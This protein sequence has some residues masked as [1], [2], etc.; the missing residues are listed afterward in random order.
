MSGGSPAA[1][2]LDGLFATIQI[3]GIQADRDRM[4]RG[5][6]GVGKPD[7]PRLLGSITRGL[8]RTAGSDLVEAHVL[9]LPVRQGEL[10]LLWRG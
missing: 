6:Q 1:P 10:E 5:D 7:K 2:L 4:V 9:C 8:I 3:T